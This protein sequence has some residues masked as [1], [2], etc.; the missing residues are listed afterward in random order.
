M[1]DVS[2]F[3]TESYRIDQQIW[4]AIA[5]GSG[6]RALFL[7]QANDG[8]WIRRAV[9]IGVEVSVVASDDATIA[10]IER[11]GATAIRGSATMIPA[12]ENAYDV[13]V[14]MHYLHE[15]DPGFHSQ[16]VSE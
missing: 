15:I 1:S 7:G 16:I 8:A 6:E 5:L 11:F 2:E 4:D 9:E 13:A 14:A 12:R 10:G 3:Q